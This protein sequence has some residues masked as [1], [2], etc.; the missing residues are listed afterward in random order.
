MTLEGVDHQLIH[1]QQ[2]KHLNPEALRILPGGR[3]YLFVQF[4]GDTCV[5]ITRARE[6]GWSRV[7]RA[8]R[9]RV[10]VGCTGRP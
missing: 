6:W 7:G 9:C 1:Y 10:T 2:K 5:M 4:A 8:A 3:A